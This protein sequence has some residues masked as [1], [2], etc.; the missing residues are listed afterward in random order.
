MLICVIYCDL[1]CHLQPLHPIA[2]VSLQVQSEKEL[3]LRSEEA[4]ASLLSIGLVNSSVYAV[5]EALLPREVQNSSG[6]EEEEW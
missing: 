4:T 3:I 5:F 6:D 1:T 2:A